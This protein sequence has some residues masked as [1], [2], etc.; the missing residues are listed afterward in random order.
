MSSTERTRAKLLAPLSKKRTILWSSCFVLALLVFFVFSESLFAQVTTAE[1]VGTAMDSS[2][3]LVPGVRLSLRNKATGEEFTATSDSAGNYSFRLLPIGHYSMQ[4]EMEGFKKWVSADVALAVGD[5]LRQEVRLELGMVEQ[6]VEVAASTPALQ[7]DTSSLGSL[8]EERAV[9]NLPLNGRNFVVL[10]QLAAGSAGEGNTSLSMASGARPDDRRRSSS[11]TVNAFEPAYNNYQIDGMDNNE[12]Y[13]GTVVVKP[14]IDALAEVKVQTLLVPAEMGRTSAGSINLLTKSGANEFH[15][16]LFEFF[17]NE[18]MDARNFFAAPGPKPSYKQN[19]F[20]GSLGG[21]IRK[22]RTF[23]FGDYE[24]FRLRQGQTTVSTIPTVAERAGNFAGVAAIYDPLTTR[25][26]SSSSTGYIR[27]PFPNSQIPLSSMDAAGIKAINLYPA[28]MNSALANNYTLSPN[29]QQR[30]DTM[31]ARVD[32]RIS[33]RDTF[34]ARYSFNDTFTYTPAA[35]PIVSDG[36]SAVGDVS[37]SGP[38]YQRAQGAQITEIH[39]FSPKLVGEFKGRLYP[40]CNPEPAAQQRQYRF[41]ADR[42]QRNQLRLGQ[43]RP[44]PD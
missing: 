8:T 25:A 43:F 37:F 44:Q 16:T 34:Y 6:T 21:P 7:T 39:S 42:H 28:P 13:T 18:K 14:S 31:D 23:F 3:S 17:R 27:T 38:A 36:I 4:A 19:Q 22:N 33:D 30:D 32:H 12:A 15:G 29:K 24:G 1:V 26:D 20:G 10:A 2:G 35:F 41:P 9:Q 11:V 5:R 40:P